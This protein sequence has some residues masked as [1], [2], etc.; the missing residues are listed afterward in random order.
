MKRY[1]LL[2][3]I[4]VISFLVSNVGEI[5]SKNSN[6]LSKCDQCLDIMIDHFLAKE[7]TF[8]TKCKAECAD[9]ARKFPGN[10]NHLY[11]MCFLGCQSGIIIA[12]TAMSESLDAQ[13]RCLAK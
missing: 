8:D 1:L 10:M 7:E 4:L 13:K 3:V 6:N 12:N 5:Q 11:D 2:G 9:T